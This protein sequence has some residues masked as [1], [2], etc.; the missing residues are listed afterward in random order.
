MR[1]LSA[2]KSRGGWAEGVFRFEYLFT[3]RFGGPQMVPSSVFI[4]LRAPDR[5]A[6][7]QTKWNLLKHATEFN[8]CLLFMYLKWNCVPCAKVME[9]CASLFSYK[10]GKSIPLPIRSGQ[11]K[12]LRTTTT[13]SSRA[14]SLRSY[15]ISSLGQLVSGCFVFWFLC[16]VAFTFLLQ[17]KF[18]A[19]TNGPMQIHF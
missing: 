10:A 2:Y 12:G 8:S 16:P 17:N 7:G 9:R 5:D 18:D 4:M 11:A 15:F 6:F 13:A 1:H 19:V 14:D 3:R